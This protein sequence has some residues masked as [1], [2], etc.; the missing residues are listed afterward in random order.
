[1]RLTLPALI[2]AA[3]GCPHR[4]SPVDGD[5]AEVVARVADGLRVAGDTAAAAEAVARRRGAEPDVIAGMCVTARAAPLLADTLDAAAS[6]AGIPGV[7]LDL[8]ACGDLPA[9]V[10]AQRIADGAAEVSEVVA[11]L[12]GLLPSGCVRDRVQGW[13]EWGGDAADA[14]ERAARGGAV[15]FAL[16]AYTPA[17]CA[18]ADRMADSG[19][20]AVSP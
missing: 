12:L 6:G 17:L 4:P 20:S 19:D 3:C 8:S 1:M 18:T 15:T 14:V 11:P 10:L 5:A 2:L 13:T 7:S 9:S 16:P